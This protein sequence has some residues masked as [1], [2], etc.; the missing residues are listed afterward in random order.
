MREVY[1]NWLDKHEWARWGR[2]GCSS[3]GMGF[4]FPWTPILEMKEHQHLH[5]GQAVLATNCRDEDRKVSIVIATTEEEVDDLAREYT[6]FFKFWPLPS[7]T[8]CAWCGV[9]HER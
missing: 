8:A 2:W 7:P 9:H 4:S 6:H 1:K 5:M 3:D